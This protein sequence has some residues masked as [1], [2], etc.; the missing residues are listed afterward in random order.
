MFSAGIIAESQSISIQFEMTSMPSKWTGNVYG[1]ALTLDWATSIGVFFQNLDGAIQGYTADQAKDHIIDTTSTDYQPWYMKLPGI[2][3]QGNPT[4][5]VDCKVGIIRSTA[6]TTQGGILLTIS[7]NSNDANSNFFDGLDTTAPD[8]AN[9]L[10]A[11]GKTSFRGI[12]TDLGFL[13]ANDSNTALTYYVEDT[14]TIA[15][16]DNSTN[17]VHG[18]D[19]NNGKWRSN[20]FQWLASDGFDNIMGS[21]NIGTYRTLEIVL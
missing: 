15:N 6:H 1:S 7:T 12:S 4:D 18:P 11:I 16:Y 17:Y 5:L 10:P 19:G 14:T 13:P 8:S 20:S 3:Y 2:D 21:S 9:S